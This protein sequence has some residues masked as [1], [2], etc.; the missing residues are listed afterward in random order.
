MS[1]TEKNEYELIS[2]V[3]EGRVE[4]FDSLVR[5]YQRSIYFL[6]FRMVRQVEE[7]DEL[8]QQT[9]LQ[10]YKSLKS[11]KGESSFKTWLSKI[12]LNLAKTALRKYKKNFVLFD[13]NKAK[14]SEQAGY[15]TNENK[16]WVRKFLEKL[17]KIQKE[18]LV[19]RVYEE[20]SFQEIADL[21][22]SKEATVKVNF[23]YA[24]KQLKAWWRQARKKDEL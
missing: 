24:L 3:L 5:K 10:A 23:H 22:T 1:G 21:L 19:L 12:A 18:V 6:I 15:E 20:K 2:E 13:E 17:P 11:F 9:F 16:N 14:A 8:T 7:A 4:V